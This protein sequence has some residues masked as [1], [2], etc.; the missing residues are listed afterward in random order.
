M[1]RTDAAGF[2]AKVRGRE[3]V[4][5]YWIQLDSP[6]STERVAR[7]GY[8]Y[9]SL[10]AQHGLFGYAG[11]LAALTA[12]DAAGRAVG[13]VRVDANNATPIGRA[14]DAGASGVIVPLVNTAADAAAAVAASRYPPTGIRSYGPTRSGM[15]IGPTPAAA[16]AAVL[17]LAMIETTE[18]LANVE[19]IAATPGLDGLYIGPSD[20]AL[21][22]GGAGPGDPAVADAFEAALARIRRACEANGLAAGLHTR[23]GEEAAKRAAEGFTLLTVASDIV[24]LEAA[25][26]AHLAAADHVRSS[27]TGA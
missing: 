18:G 5:G 21:A 7:L 19:E 14:L 4:V 2:A 23:S 24:H 10:D 12:I 16:D 6:A 26:A 11:M 27:V 22:V 13:L 25:A 15:R 3:T 8:D 20:L 1:T 17:V 9:V